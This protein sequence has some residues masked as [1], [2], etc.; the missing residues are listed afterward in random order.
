MANRPY[1]G[2]STI[3]PA[4]EILDR[5]V[6]AGGSPNFIGSSCRRVSATDTAACIRVR[7]GTG[8]GATFAD[9]LPVAATGWVDTDQLATFAAGSNVFLHTIYDK[10]GNGRN[11]V[12]S[13]EA[14]Q[15]KIY[16]AS[17]GSVLLG[18]LLTANFV[19]ATPTYYS[20]ADAC[21]L[22]GSVAGSMYLFGAYPNNAAASVQVAMQVGALVSGQR[23][24]T[25]LSNSGPAFINQLSNTLLRTFT[26]Q[27]QWDEPCG[28]LASIAASALIGAST[29]RQMSRTE[30][31]DL[32]Q[33]SVAGAT[34]CSFTNTAAGIGAR[35]NGTL[36]AGGNWCVWAIFGTA[37]SAGVIAAMDAFS[38]ALCP[39]AYEASIV[40]WG[41]SNESLIPLSV[42]P[43]V[44][45]AQRRRASQG[46]TA[47]SAWAR[48]TALYLELVDEIGKTPANRPVFLVCRHGESDATTTLAASY[49]AAI[50]QFRTDLEVDTGRSIYWIVW[51]LH[52]SAA[53]NQ[54]GFTTTA[55]DSISTSW[56][57]FVADI[58]GRAVYRQPADFAGGL[59][60]AEAPFPTHYSATLQT[61]T[62]IED[63][64][65]VVASGL[66]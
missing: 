51:G 59:D 42:I 30:A 31:W 58:P 41:Q 39:Y 3:D 50:R 54:V 4:L 29:V 60:A 18:T 6:A 11:F 9:I 61:N 49:L 25:G 43:E 55:R 34:A 14:N 32:A 23:F 47:I 24:E 19:A 52:T 48:N 8:G 65:L 22:T 5:I 12:Q 26:K 53:Y 27:D 1:T 28:Y 63:S 21:G 33:A 15:A 56:Q 46:G 2:G 7:K 66:L 13:T 17:T 40:G 44:A 20:R 57:T 64:A 37:P 62:S 38:A 16:D 36:G 10:S 45:G 35:S